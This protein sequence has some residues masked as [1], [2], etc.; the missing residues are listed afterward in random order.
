MKIAHSALVELIRE[1]F[2]TPAIVD[3]TMVSSSDDMPVVVNPSVDDSMV[4][5]EVTPV[6]IAYVPRDKTEFSIAV[7]SL[8]KHLPDEVIPLL[9]ARVREIVLDA[10]DACAATEDSGDI[11]NMPKKRDNSPLGQLSNPGKLGMEE[12][13]RRSIRKMIS[14][15]TE[16]ERKRDDEEKVDALD[17]PTVDVPVDS[18][19]SEEEELTPATDTSDVDVE[20][21]WDPDAEAD[22]EEARLEKEKQE[23]EKASSSPKGEADL[24]KYIA[25]EMGIS[26]SGATRLKTTGLAKLAHMAKMD[27]EDVLDYMFDKVNDYV[28]YLDRSGELTPEEVSTLKRHPDIVIDLDGFREFLHKYIRKD[29]KAAGDWPYDEKDE[30]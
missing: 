19:D 20:S 13:L 2:D 4:P 18:E 3:V 27:H 8:T 12:A 14:E 10:E 5:V 28:K 9:Y 17:E 6:D 22:E 15:E 21:P 26:T 24:M 29:V 23:R 16:E 11:E 30:D 7:K 25:S 1:A